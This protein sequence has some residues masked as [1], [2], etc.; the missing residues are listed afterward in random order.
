MPIKDDLYSALKALPRRYSIQNE[1]E[2]NGWALILMPYPTAPHNLHK[3][4]LSIQI[5]VASSGR[6]FTLYSPLAIFTAPT[7]NNVLEHLLQRNFYA[8]QTGGAT[9]AITQINDIDTLMAVY[10]WLFDTISPEMFQSML[11][12]FI[13]ACFTLMTEIDSIAAKSKAIQPVNSDD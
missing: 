3:D 4:E 5:R 1:L 9:L 13:K 2:K 7:E 6:F 11:D 10:H 8:D 12:N